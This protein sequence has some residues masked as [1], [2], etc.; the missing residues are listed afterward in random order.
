[1]AVEPDVSFFL[2]KSGCLGP[3]SAALS[4]RK[5][6]E[7]ST[8]S[9]VNVL[10]S[11]VGR[12]D[13]ALEG[14]SDGSIVPALL[15]HYYSS[16]SS[17]VLEAVFRALRSLVTTLGH[18]LVTADDESLSDGVRQV[19]V[20]CFCEDQFIERI[21][22]VLSASANVTV[23]ETA[24][25]LLFTIMET[26]LEVLDE[27]T[28]MASFSATF[29]TP[30]LSMALVEAGLQCSDQESVLFHVLEVLSH[31]TSMASSSLQGC[32]SGAC[33]VASLYLSLSL[34]HNDLTSVASACHV[35]MQ[36]WTVERH[37]ESRALVAS[38][39][40]KL[41]ASEADQS[42]AALASSL[43]SALTLYDQ[44]YGSASV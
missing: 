39:L 29:C 11:V 6:S 24:S 5:T 1:M 7:E 3:I 4:A 25:K 17:E 26:C 20:Q 33:N 8:V 35:C 14:I 44:S 10:A 21:S 12:P 30:Q 31:L 38:L 34:S 36:C 43:T 15:T 9:L 37:D 18:V 13:V 41:T 32:E 42:A 16:S 23:L 28:S 2:A 22:F 19:V 40:S 27:E